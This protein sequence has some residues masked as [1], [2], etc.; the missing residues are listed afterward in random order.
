MKPA[1]FEYHAPATVDEAVGLLKR[2]NGE[3]R[4]LAGG[5]SLIPM[6]NFRVAAPAALV[7]L[8]R[9][10]SLA[11]IRADGDTVRIGAMTRQRAIEFSP[12]VRE[13]LP[14]L[15]EA[16]SW[17]GHLPTRSRGTIGGSLAHADPAAE[18]PMALQALEGE[19]V[20]RGPAGERT[21]KAG[22]LF[23]SSLTTTLKPDEILT[24]IRFPASPPG[25]AYAVEE[26]ARRHG[27]FAITAIAC[28]L[29]RDGTRCKMARLATGGVGPVPLRLTAA[30]TILEQRGL[31]EDA[32]EAAAA[33]AAAAVDPMSDHQGSAE[34]RRH[35][36][37]VLTRRAVQKAL[38][39]KP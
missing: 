28:L 33:A 17:V 20:A 19:V 26:F 16:I 15:H 2:Y 8:N 21:I 38:A 24:E 13:K 3:A 39:R 1:K 18:L 5:Q 22:D 11:Y 30:E 31:A 35:L 27:D 37:Q 29:V 23:S 14:L 10:P 6:M 36:T 32:I 9:I 25:A 34:Y 4:V 7:D 12:V